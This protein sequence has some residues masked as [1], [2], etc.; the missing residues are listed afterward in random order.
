MSVNTTKRDIHHEIADVIALLGDEYMTTN[1]ECSLGDSVIKITRQNNSKTM[2]LIAYSNPDD[3]EI[4]L[5][6][7][8]DSLI[9]YHVFHDGSLYDSTPEDIADYITRNL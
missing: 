4:H 5:Y 8:P 3:T 1:V 6:D 2:Y 9:T 7:E